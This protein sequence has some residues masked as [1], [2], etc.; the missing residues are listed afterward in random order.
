MP[1]HWKDNWY[2]ERREDGSVR[3]YH[4]DSG[5]IPSIPLDDDDY[6]EYD[7][8]L[9]IDKDS[10][11]SIIASVSERGETAETFKEAGEFHNKN[12]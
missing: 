11:A 6:P 3:I 9:D 5:S 7:V 8:C 10:W 12:T 2:F 1:F 4:E